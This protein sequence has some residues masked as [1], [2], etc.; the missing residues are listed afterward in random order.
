[1][2]YLS[3]SEIVDLHQTLLDQ[4]GGAVRPPLDTHRLESR[5]GTL[6]S[7]NDFMKSSELTHQPDPA[8]I[9]TQHIKP[10][11]PAIWLDRTDI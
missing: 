2:R 4:T 8:A 11:A 3:L 10:Y 1:M 9:V 6:D 5:I 7:R